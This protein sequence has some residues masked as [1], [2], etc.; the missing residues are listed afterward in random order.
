MARE[1]ERTTA[2]NQI[3]HCQELAR[4]LIDTPI[5][6]TRTFG[7]IVDTATNLQKIGK[8]AEYAE[9]VCGPVSFHP[10]SK[11]QRDELK[12]IFVP[13]APGNSPD[14]DPDVAQIRHA[15]S[16][17]DDQ[18]AVVVGERG[19][20]KTLTINYV[21]ACEWEQLRR[22]RIVVFRADVVK[23][24]QWN[25]RNRTKNTPVTIDEYM[26][27]H[28]YYIA[29]RFGMMPVGIRRDPLLAFFEPAADRTSFHSYL[30]QCDHATTTEQLWD[31]VIRFFKRN[32]VEFGDRADEFS[33][34]LVVDVLRRAKHDAQALYR[35]FTRAIRTQGRFTEQETA[36][37]V[38][39]IDG[40]DNV[41]RHRG[42]A[43]YDR[44]LGELNVF[45][46]KRE[47]AKR[48]D[49]VLLV[50]R[51]D[52]FRDLVTRDT[53]L[54]FERPA[55][56]LLIVVAQRP[57]QDVLARRAGIAQEGTSHLA[58]KSRK[59]KKL[60]ADEFEAL[61]NGLIPYG[62]DVLVR[63][64]RGRRFMRR[65]LR[66]ARRSE[67]DA[68]V[69]VFNSNMRC[70]LKCICRGYD[71]VSR[72]AQQSTHS[73]YTLSRKL[74]AQVV[75]EGSLLAGCK[76]F[77]ST[78]HDYSGRWCPNLFEWRLTDGGN[79]WIGLILVR[80]LQLAAVDEHNFTIERLRSEIC[81]LFRYPTGRV[82]EMIL[83]AFEFG[84]I[85][86]KDVAYPER[87]GTTE[88][89]PD[90][91]LGKPVIGLTEKGRLI[92]D[93]PFRVLNVMY[94]MALSVKLDLKALGF[95]S[96]SDYAHSPEL[97][98]DTRRFR[99]PVVL[100]TIAMLRHIKTAHDREMGFVRASSIEMSPHFELPPTD[101][102]VHAIE[103]TISTM[104]T[105]SLDILNTLLIKTMEAHHD[106]AC[107]R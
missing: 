81:R 69:A 6:W 95:P 38:G 104:P 88:H 102:L 99:L 83:V 57:I 17:G 107:S 45:T 30:A 78:F 92:R 84:L 68:F 49:K 34:K 42:N 12:S 106:L 53:T 33:C 77:P 27:A 15:L 4:V 40:V 71:Y 54:D 46:Q 37:I 70:F 100:T 72:Y 32:V 82:E 80:V 3:R 66:D 51:N 9:D 93:L 98:V 52:T 89:S 29:L 105:K 39:I 44:L 48:F 73:T 87:P 103:E 35:Y 55:I 58:E 16:S 97:A 79:V 64:A 23:L 61:R 2:N 26:Q 63:L 62:K 24:N 50:M 13:L 65:G 31:R 1:D 60:E 28:S 74:R 8:F 21:L 14:D 7:S 86:N 85:F 90:H 67:Q 20:G 10:F 41:V 91:R 25:E 75:F 43:V 11:T 94:F 59:N 96:V 47:R 56:G 22:K 101:R 5:E 19:A 18:C 36:K 76:F